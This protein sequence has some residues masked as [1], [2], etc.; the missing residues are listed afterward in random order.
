MTRSR[1]RR[2]PSPLE[3]AR[4]TTERAVAGVTV[5]FGEARLGH[6]IRADQ[7]LA[8]VDDL[9]SAMMRD[10]GA[11]VTVT[12]MK[13]RDQYTYI[14]SVAVSAL[15]MG[16]AR[17][18]DFGEE[19]VRVAGMAGLVHDIGKIQVPVAIVDKTGP[20]TPDELATMRRHP[21]MGHATLMELGGLDPRIL[22][23]CHAHH[24]K[25]DGSGYP[26]GLAGDALSVFAR[27]A[28][29]CDVY[30]AVTSVRSYKRAWSPHDALA[31]MLEW[32]G[33]FDMAILHAFIASLDIQPLGALVRLRSN[34]LGVVV[35]D[36]ETPAT[37]VVRAFFDVPDHQHMRARDVR[38]EDDPII[39]TERGEY[40]FGD[41]W[42]ALHATLMEDL[43][44]CPMTRAEPMETRR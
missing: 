8:I 2:P 35:R 34:R 26:N 44:V 33:H 10:A 9:A 28:A 22:D 13:D 5:L 16:L 15:M 40:W 38:T 1:R 23:V 36:G 6:A 19:D 42:P 4:A 31:Q 29:I 20:L 12:R 18:L 43:D 30:D 39:R 37:P 3:A 21:A 41:R 7:L 17:Q 27:M 14:H 32:H 24:E 11:M 25:L